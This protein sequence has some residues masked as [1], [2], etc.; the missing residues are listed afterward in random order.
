MTA[1]AP[2]WPGFSRRFVEEVRRAADIVRLISEH[3]S[4]QEDGHLVEGLVPLS[5]GEDARPSTSA[6]SPPLF[7]CFGCGEGGDVFKFVMLRER[8]GLP[9]GGRDRGAPL[10]V[11][12]P[13]NGHEAGPERKERDQI[14]ALMEAAAEHFART[15]WTAPGHDGPR[16]PAGPRLQ[17]GDPRGASARAPP[18]TRGRT[19]RGLQ[20]RLPGVGSPDAR[21]SCSR[22]REGDGHYDRFR[23]RAL[24]PILNDSGKVVAFGGRSL[25]G[26]EPKYLNS[27]ETPGL[28]E[29]PH[30]LRALLGEG[31]DPQGGPRRPDGRVPRRRSGPRSGHLGVSWPPAARR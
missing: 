11:A 14:L 1:A 22:S 24:F 19:P 31:G 18:P 5:P 25:D 10:R 3:V 12:V 29:G 23:N 13:E 15:L 28:P 6:P 17:A 16:V 4:A 20:R 7:H 9:G 8:V 26:S 27:P 2:E 21:G 30:A